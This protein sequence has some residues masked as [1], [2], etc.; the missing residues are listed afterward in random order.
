MKLWE[1]LKAKAAQG[2]YPPEQMEPYIAGKKIA[3]PGAAF[4]LAMLLAGVIALA[5]V[6]GASL[7][8]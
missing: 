3:E 7:F 4:W 2:Q 8:K 1:V 5:L 6:C